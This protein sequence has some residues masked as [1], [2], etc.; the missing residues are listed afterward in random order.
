MDQPG[1]D[2][3]PAKWDGYMCWNAA[4][5]GTIN[6]QTCPSMTYF[7]LNIKP[8]SCRNEISS[9]ECKSNS[10]WARIWK[11]GCNSSSAECSEEYTNYLPCSTPG[12]TRKL[13]LIHL[14]IGTYL[15]SLVLTIVGV[16]LL[17]VFPLRKLP[18]LGIVHR[19][20]LY[21]LV[22]TS[23]FSLSVLI[24]IKRQHYKLNSM[25]DKK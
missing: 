18:L 11:D 8:T 9:K 23:L 16:T 3:C 19:N 22:I 15:I 13:N 14:S 2:Y 5:A 21:S 24:F 6:Y 25:I 20:F 17:H 4:K 1:E 12:A 10:T 7:A